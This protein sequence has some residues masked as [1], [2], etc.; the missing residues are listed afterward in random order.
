MKKYTLLL[1][2]ILYS[3]KLQS[4]GLYYSIENEKKIEQ[5]KRSKALKG[6]NINFM[7]KDGEFYYLAL[8][9]LY[10]RKI[11]SIEED[12]YY[13]WTDARNELPESF[14]NIAKIIDD[15][16][17]N[18]VYAV[19]FDT[20]GFNTFLYKKIKEV[21]GWI[22]V[23]INLDEG[24]SLLSIFLVEGELILNTGIKQEYGTL[25]KLKYLD[26]KLIPGYKSPISVNK[27]IKIESNLFVIN[28][29]QIF[30]GT[31]TL[32]E[33]ILPFYRDKG[34][35]SDIIYYK[36]KILISTLGGYLLYSKDQGDT[37]VDGARYTFD[38]EVGY[39]IKCL[40][41]YINDEGI[42]SLFACIMNASYIEI[43][44]NADDS[45]IFKRIGVLSGNLFSTELYNSTVESFYEDDKNLFALSN[46]ALL[47]RAIWNKDRNGL[48][49][50]QE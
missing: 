44:I 41:N 8:T 47:W 33:I 11:N 27:I 4:Q 16:D 38:S 20:S 22:K 21:D 34:S 28:D 2:V 49:W 10:K 6:Q 50:T 23:D 31:D 18:T 45:I 48:I 1:L 42:N 29:R 7:F 14:K 25:N 12:E 35:Y 36:D 32:E 15:K 40:Y 19:L 13:K 5:E 43:N 39:S 24:E 37:W 3:C 26:G 46:R 9:S 30:K 17:N